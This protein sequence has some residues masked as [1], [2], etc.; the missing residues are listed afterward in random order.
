M[1]RKMIMG[2]VMAM[3]AF[4]AVSAMS[5]T[6]L[7]IGPANASAATAMSS[8]DPGEF[9]RDASLMVQPNDAKPAV[10]QVRVLYLRPLGRDVSSSPKGDRLRFCQ[11]MTP[12]PDGPTL[13]PKAPWPLC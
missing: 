12:S 5:L 1:I 10:Y 4:A 7:A 6:S 8:L 13:I 2:S 9:L 11:V 3:A